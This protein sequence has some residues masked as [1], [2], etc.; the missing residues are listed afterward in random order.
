M[1]NMNPL[2]LATS[3]VSRYTT[4]A[5][6]RIPQEVRRRLEVVLD[7]DD[8]ARRIAELGHAGDDR[9]GEPRVLAS[10]VDVHGRESGDG[11]RLGA[12]VLTRGSSSLVP[13][14]VAEDVELALGRQVVGPKRLDRSLQVRRPVEGE[15]GDRREIHG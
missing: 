4:S 3:G 15:E 9:G 6:L 2:T 10:L 1:G 11:A 5:S 13:R 7:D 8:R 12:N 14:S